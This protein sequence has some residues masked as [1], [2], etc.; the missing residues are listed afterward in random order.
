MLDFEKKNSKNRGNDI[1][2]LKRFFC[3]N[4][5][6]GRKYLLKPE[7]LWLENIAKPN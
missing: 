6:L 4:K 2:P 7:K 3:D 1:V 5:N